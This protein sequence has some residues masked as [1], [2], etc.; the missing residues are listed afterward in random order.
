[1]QALRCN[2]PNVVYAICYNT[3]FGEKQLAI[4]NPSNLESQHNRVRPCDNNDNII[5]C[6]SRPWQSIRPAS[7]ATR[8]GVAPPHSDY[9][10]E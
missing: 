6:A 4:L 10:N 8:S 9:Q 2:L 7:F 5:A 1:M 3:L